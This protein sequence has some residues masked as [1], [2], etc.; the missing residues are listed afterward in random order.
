MRQLPTR[1]LDISGFQFLSTPEL[2]GVRAAMA[3]DVQ[4]MPCPQLLSVH[5]AISPASG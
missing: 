2:S 3:G 1:L 4:P 5:C